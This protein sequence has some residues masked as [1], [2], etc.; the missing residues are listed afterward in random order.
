[1][2]INPT[3]GIGF[4]PCGLAIDASKSFGD[5]AFFFLLYQR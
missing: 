5:N 1:M 3:I 4:A 2:A